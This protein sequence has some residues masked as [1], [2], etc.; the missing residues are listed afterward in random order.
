MFII[1]L[2]VLNYPAYD[3]AIA[4]DGDTESLA[5]DLLTFL[6]VAV[7]FAIPLGKFLSWWKDFLADAQASRPD[8]IV[9]GREDEPGP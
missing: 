9:L 3:A 7:F 8:K 4:F 5:Q 6:S 1:V 2:C